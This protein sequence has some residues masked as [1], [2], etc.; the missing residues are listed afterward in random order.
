MHQVA[1]DVEQG[2][3]VVFDVHDVAVPK[4]LVKRF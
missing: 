1:I 3:A 2:R 4:F